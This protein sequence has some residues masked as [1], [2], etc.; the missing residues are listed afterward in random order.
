MLEAALVVPLVLSV[1]VALMFVC[2]YAGV[3]SLAFSSAGIAAERA[4]FAW[5]NSRRNPVTGA[6]FPGL[7]DDLYWRITGDYPGSA[8]AGRKV[9][10]ALDSAG[11]AGSR[12]GRYE[13]AVWR[14]KVTI[15]WAAPFRMPDPQKP[16]GKAVLKTQWSEAI[17][18]EPAEWVRT[19]GLARQYW[20]AVERVIDRGEADRMVDEFRRRPGAAREAPAFSRHA[21]AVDYLQRLVGGRVKQMATEEVGHYRRIEAF[22]R[23]GIAHHAYLGE[24]TADRDIRD[25]FLKD[26]ELIR[27]GLVKG[28]V[29]HFFRRADTG[30][31]GPSDALRKELEKRGIVIVI[32]E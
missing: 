5:D 2:L 10:A 21:D 31:I 15:G 13:N 32:H 9:E 22:D 26:E 19:V 6:F 20:P 1:T 24:K 4:A 18:V 25:Q 23:H 8:L 12:E 27:K 14:R 28:V 3:Q 17:V 7:Y 29:W 11:P 16:A 30:A